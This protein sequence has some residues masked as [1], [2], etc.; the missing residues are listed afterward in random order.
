VGCDVLIDNEVF[1]MIGFVNLKIKPIQSFRGA[2]R[3]KVCV[4]VFIEV[5]ARV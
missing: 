2:H 3:D 4:Y 1:L 5:S